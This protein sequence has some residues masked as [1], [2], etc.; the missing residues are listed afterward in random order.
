MLVDQEG[1]MH[2]SRSSFS[3]A[4]VIAVLASQFS[5]SKHI[6]TYD[7]LSFSFKNIIISGVAHR[8]RRWRVWLGLGRFALS[9]AVLGMSGVDAAQAQSAALRPVNPPASAVDAALGDPSSRFASPGYFR[10]APSP[11][12][13]GYYAAREGRPDSS[14]IDVENFR[15][16]PR[17]LVDEAYNNNVYAHSSHQKDDAITTINPSVAAT[18]LWDVHALSFLASLRQGVYDRF[19]GEDFTDGL[20]LSEGRFDVDDDSALSG[21][22]LYRHSH[23]PRG[24]PDDAHGDTPTPF[25]DTQAR[26]DYTRRAG[27]AVGELELRYETVT[28]FDVGS[29]NGPINSG[30]L[31]R[32]AF[33]PRLRL[34]Y[35]VIPEALQLFVQTRYRNTSYR[36]LALGLDRDSQTFEQVIGLRVTPGGPL[37]GEV[38]VGAL[39]Q[40]YLSAAL[41]SFV[42]PT[43]GVS[44]AWTPTLLTTVRLDAGRSVEDAAF[45]GFSGYRQTAAT[46]AID[47]ELL[48]A[49][50][51]N[52]SLFFADRD[53]I[54]LPRHETFMQ[55]SVGARYA[56]NDAITV[57]PSLG[58]SERDANFSD[59]SFSQVV[60]LFR[61]SGR[62]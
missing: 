16:A 10:Q 42:T 49:V 32:S 36:E 19:S 1:E 33:T 17:L 48:R 20:I 51:L 5:K 52:T 39:K 38:L 37:S 21:S 41:P 45:S 25:D 34:G 58:V 53:Y 30:V 46:L 18:S 29:P 9:I 55:I 11:L 62:L 14:G 26:L 24:S 27:D 35:A 40:Q 60:A 31:D 43:F 15:V 13:F 2:R 44:L 61:L 22:V 23:V 28:Y 12:D 56:I 6:F 50:L 47:H 8:I 54:G 7:S 59:S 3:R 4:A 57:G